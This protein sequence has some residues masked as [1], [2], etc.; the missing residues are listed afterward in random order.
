MKLV[1]GI[2]GTVYIRRFTFEAPKL[3]QATGMFLGINSEPCRMCSLMQFRNECKTLNR[4]QLIIMAM[5][6]PKL[7]S[8]LTSKIII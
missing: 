2:K 6:K 1:Q 4:T 7:V 3:A 8:N 5:L